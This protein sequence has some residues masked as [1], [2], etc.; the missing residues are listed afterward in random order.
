M[1]V[2][3]L[4]AIGLMRSKASMNLRLEAL[5]YVPGAL[6][7]ASCGIMLFECLS[8]RQF[9]VAANLMLITSGAALLVF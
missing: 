6:V 3:A 8:D 9:A 7:G 2:F 4:L 1:Q 5:A